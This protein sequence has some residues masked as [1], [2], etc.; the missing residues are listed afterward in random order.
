MQTE[1]RRHEPLQGA[2]PIVAADEMC[3]LVQNDLIEGFGLESADQAFGEHDERPA[4]ET[5]ARSAPATSFETTSSARRSR[6]ERRL[7]WGS[8][9][10]MASSSGRAWWRR[11]AIARRADASLHP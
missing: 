6:V 5:D 10:A 7:Q 3:A 9:R 11:V 1:A 2:C 8:A 4:R